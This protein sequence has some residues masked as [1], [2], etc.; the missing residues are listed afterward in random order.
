MEYNESTVRKIS[1]VCYVIGIWVSIALALV[2]A[3]C[4]AKA[5]SHL[6]N[7]QEEYRTSYLYGDKQS[8]PEITYNELEA[9]VKANEGNIPID[10]YYITNNV[11]KNAKQSHGVSLIYD[12]S[13]STYGVSI[14]SFAWETY[15]NG[16]TFKDSDA[17]AEYFTTLLNGKDPV[18]AYQIIYDF[19]NNN[20]FSE[21]YN[22]NVSYNIIFETFVYFVMLVALG[23]RFYSLNHVAVGGDGH[24][25]PMI[26]AFI[27]RVTITGLYSLITKRLDKKAEQKSKEEKFEDNYTSESV[28][29]DN[30]DNTAWYHKIVSAFSVDCGNSVRSLIESMKQLNSYYENISEDSSHNF[31]NIYCKELYS[32][33]TSIREQ[34]QRGTISMKEEIIAI[35]KTCSLYHDIFVSLFE[36][37]KE[38]DRMS[39]D[40]YEISNEAMRKYAQ[41]MGHLDSDEISQKNSSENA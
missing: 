41:S 27:P 23:Y 7:S 34:F 11:I 4:I 40:N 6:H 10:F 36:R 19:N 8:I 12:Q 17:M 18:S 26:V 20:G 22:Q 31:Y 37:I 9:A 15:C 25:I 16:V 29:Q 5:V 39:S 21:V 24:L 1:H 33:L 3:F 32:T 35:E 28:S 14:E 38:R 13:T 30:S 2:A